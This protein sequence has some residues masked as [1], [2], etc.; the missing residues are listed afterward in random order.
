MVVVFGWAL[1]NVV[2]VGLL[3]VFGATATETGLYG[4]SI[5]IVTGFGLAAALA[6]ARGRT[7]QQLRQPTRS[8]SAFLFAAAGLLVGLGAVYHWWIAVVAI[9][10][11]AAALVLRAAERLPRGHAAPAPVTTRTDL[12]PPARS[13]GPLPYAG[14]PLGTSV[15]VPADHPAHAAA[16]PAR[17]AWMRAGRWAVIVAAVLH[18]VFRVAVRRR[19]TRVSR[20]EPS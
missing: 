10:P 11:L 7:G 8:G 4:A 5:G 18:T 16:R 3:P 6:A 12:A 2:L 9:Y 1:F 17:P 19:L 13:G 20:G 15:S 14:S